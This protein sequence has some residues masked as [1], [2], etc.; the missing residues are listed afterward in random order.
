MDSGKDNGVK[1]P[2]PLPRAVPQTY[3]G[4]N[5]QTWCHRAAV[6]ALILPRMACTLAG[7]L[8][9]LCGLRCSGK[10]TESQMATTE[11]PDNSGWD[12]QVRDRLICT[13]QQC[14]IACSPGVVEQSIPVRIINMESS[15]DFVSNTSEHWRVSDDS[16]L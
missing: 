16:A 10:R 1:E 7:P 11:L 9:L 5:T 2:V 15:S 14:D 13:T 4:D 12:D 3:G 8:S 6:E